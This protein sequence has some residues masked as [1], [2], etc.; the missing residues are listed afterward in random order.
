ML[1]PH[2][3]E[4]PDPPPL[5]PI[6]D[7]P[8]PHEEMGPIEPTPMPE[9]VDLLETVLQMREAIGV[10]VKAVPLADAD[11]R[12]IAALYEPWAEGGD[13]RRITTNNEPS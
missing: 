13:R 6:P 9:G 4:Y 3:I 1:H 12:T 5:P 7:P 8:V 11:L 10:L 2:E